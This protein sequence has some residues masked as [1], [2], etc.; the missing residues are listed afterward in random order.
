MGGT[1]TSL[2]PTSSSIRILMAI[3]RG[4]IRGTVLPIG[5]VKIPR[6]G[7]IFRLFPYI[8]LGSMCWRGC[9][10][11]SDTQI[12]GGRGIHSYLARSLHRQ[13]AILF[14]T[15]KHQIVPIV[16]NITCILLLF[17]NVLIPFFLFQVAFQIGLKG[18]GF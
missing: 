16:S 5:S 9:G 17:F 2:G 14:L 3:F 8:C 15:I 13:T 7:G 11:Q 1:P 18:K 4:V 6:G 10:G 12:R